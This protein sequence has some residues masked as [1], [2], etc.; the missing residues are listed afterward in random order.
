[1]IKSKAVTIIK[2]IGSKDTDPEEKLT[3]IQEVVEMETVNSVTKQ[4]LVG[5]LKWMIEDYI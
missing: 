3:A 5:A 1:M 2:D 4:D